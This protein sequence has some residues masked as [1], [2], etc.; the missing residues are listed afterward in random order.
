[1]PPLIT[2]LTDF[3]LQDSYLGQ[4]KGAILSAC[5]DAQLVD[6]T[7][8]IA[9]G[10]ILSAALVWADALPAFPDG[11]I[12]L[13]VVDPGVGSA[14]KAIA[15]EIGPWKVVCPDNG[16]A[17]YLLARHGAGW[18]VELNESRWWRNPVSPVF[19]G[20]DLFGPVAGA[21]AAGNDL[22]LL[23]SQLTEP[24][25]TLAIEQPKIVAGRIQGSVIHIDRFGN[26]VTNIADELLAEP[27]SAWRMEI[28][29]RVVHGI[30]SHYGERPPGE[31]LA[32]IGSHGRLE[33]AV[34]QGRAADVLEAGVGTKVVA[35]AG[36]A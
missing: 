12:H 3:G 35:E 26:V 29:S 28:G 14:R 11:T 5:P 7:H 30:S 15:A 27:R 9:P 10:D 22:S 31:V 17:T 34:N 33:L 21:W 1:M 25:I 24:L 32:L 36:A 6:L 23:G 8:Q 2:L 16:L 19:H 18:A 20:R 4:M 13:A